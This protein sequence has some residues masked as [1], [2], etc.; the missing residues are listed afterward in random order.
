MIEDKS[1]VTETSTD[2][3]IEDVIDET[4]DETET[5][6]VAQVD[7]DIDMSFTN[8][9]K[10][11]KRLNSD[12]E[13][14]RAELEAEQETVFNQRLEDIAVANGFNSWEEYQE[15]VHLAQLDSL[16]V[17][18]PDAFKK[19]VEKAINESPA[20]KEAKKIIEKNKQDNQQQLIQEEI[21]QINEIDPSIKDVSDFIKMDNYDEFE[22][23]VKK[24]HT[25]VDAY[26][27]TNFDK[28]VQR[29]VDKKEHDDMVKKNS[30]SHQK[31]GKSSGLEPETIDAVSLNIFRSF[32][33]NLSD[34]DILKKYLATKGEKK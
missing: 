6:P 8:T 33:P 7:D 10:Y 30:T 3:E 22:K 21:R 31:E 12:R 27:L 32:Y 23:L 5:E 29:K 34:A 17:S 28:L 19:Y 24:G 2:E 20:I 14:I 18:D 4:D 13:R 11:T 1:D 25:L 9:Q 16:G 15:Q 26:K